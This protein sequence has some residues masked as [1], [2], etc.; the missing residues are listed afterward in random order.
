MKLS[1][2][3]LIFLFVVLIL[4]LAACG[5]IGVKTDDEI[6]SDIQT[7]DE[8]FGNFDLAVDSI[9]ISKRQTNEADKTDYVWATIY[10]SNDEFSYTADYSMTYVLYNDGWQL[11][12]FYLENQ[13]YLGSHP[14]S[15]EQGEADQAIADMGY[16]DIEF[17]DRTEYDNQVVFLYSA[18]K[19]EY[20]LKSVYDVSLVYEFVPEM[21]W[22]WY[23]PNETIKEQIPDVVGEWRYQYY[24]DNGELFV[25][26]Y[27]NI[28]N[29]DMEKETV[30]LEYNFLRYTIYR[31]IGGWNDDRQVN[32]DSGGVIT[33]PF[34]CRE[35]YY[36]DNDNT[37]LIYTLKLP[38]ATCFESYDDPP[39]I[40]L[41]LGGE[42]PVLGYGE[43]G[44]EVCH[45]NLERQA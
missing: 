25:D 32:F 33:V 8:Y 22:D 45:H 11:E 9:E 35:Q 30:N 27:V 40:L 7:M 15:V 26:Y 39:E 21:S 23:Y 38:K 4:S 16:T 28:T 13:S 3:F 37:V 12:E 29:V 2:H 31:R 43:Y 19:T 1:K 5:G 20:Y 41:Y 10:A 44:V 42:K 36:K 34:E 18:S 6:S 14:E 17:I 24:K